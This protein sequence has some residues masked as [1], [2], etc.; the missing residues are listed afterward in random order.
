[1]ET[2]NNLPYGKKQ[3]DGQIGKNIFLYILDNRFNIYV[4]CKFCFCSIRLELIF[5]MALYQTV[6]ITQL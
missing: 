6:S 3:Y 1:M 5:H 2:K 4:I